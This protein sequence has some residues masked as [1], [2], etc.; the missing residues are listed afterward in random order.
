[1]S[2]LATVE[3]P[4]NKKYIREHLAK[5]MQMIKQ[6]YWDRE[7]VADRGLEKDKNS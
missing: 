1:M 2:A 6:G 4:T 3:F 7:I 5:G